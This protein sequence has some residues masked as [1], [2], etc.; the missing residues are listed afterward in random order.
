MTTD[1]RV[2]VVVGLVTVDAVAR[3]TVMGAAPLVRF[4]GVCNNVACALGAL[5][6]Q[7]MFVT[8]RYRG[9]VGRCVATHL[10][11]YGV[12]WIPVDATAA[13]SLFVAQLDER[14]DVI[15]ETFV[16]GGSV[17]ALTAATLRAFASFIDH[18]AAAVSCTDLELDSLHEIARM[19]AQAGVPFWL[20][21]TSKVE[22]PKLAALTPKPQF[23][24]LNIGE[25][26]EIE[27]VD[28]GDICAAAEVGAKLVSPDGVCLITRGADGAQLCLSST[29]TIFVQRV[30]RVRSDSTIGAGD[31]M[32]ASLLAARLMGCSWDASL[33]TAAARVAGFVSGNMDADAVDTYA[34]LRTPCDDLPR[35]ETLR[36]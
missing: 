35:T 23:V 27:R 5:D 31:L 8:P 20:L 33:R 29:R 2:P 21:S 1:R 17:R 30:K 14:G 19:S 13:L 9:D 32:L 3:T 34:L 6:I 15:S 26:Q 25:L 36:W 7:P 12:R 10:D 22:A 11:A 16:D 4:G 24:A 28:D 18:A